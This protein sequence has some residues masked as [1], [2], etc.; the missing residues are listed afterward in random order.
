MRTRQKQRVATDT[1]RTLGC[2]TTPL[3]HWSKRKP[4][5]EPRWAQQQTKKLRP[6]LFISHPLFQKSA[7]GPVGQSIYTRVGGKSKTILDNKCIPVRIRRRRLALRCTSSL[8]T[9]LPRRPKMEAKIA[10]S[11]KDFTPFIG[12]PIFFFY[13]QILWIIIPRPTRVNAWL[14]LRYGCKDGR[15]FVER[16][17]IIHRI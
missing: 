12:V 5:V 15:R 11:Y 8:N 9:A 6:Q 17:I 10:Q 16:K 2:R 1:W 7:Y 4:T 3:E 14:Y 13:S